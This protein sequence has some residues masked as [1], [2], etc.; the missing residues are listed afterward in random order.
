VSFPDFPGCITAGRALDDASSGMAAEALALHI[1]GMLE[2]GDPLPQPSRVDDVAADA[3]RHCISSE[4]SR[5]RCAV[6]VNIIT[7][8][9]QIAKMDAPA[10]AAGLTRSTYLAQAAIAKGKGGNRDGKKTARHARVKLRS[11][12]LRGSQ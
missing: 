3:D 1:H 7:P 10:E 6:R 2:D 8:E 11:D 12:K 4:V 9:S 5:S